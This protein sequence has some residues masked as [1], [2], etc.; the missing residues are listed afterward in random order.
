[1][2]LSRWSLLLVGLLA[3]V[4]GDAG[5]RTAAAPA[6]EEAPIVVRHLKFTP[7]GPDATGGRLLG[8]GAEAK[9]LAGVEELAKLVGK[10]SADELTKQADLTKEVIVFVSWSSSGPP[11]GTLQQD[12]KGKDKERRVE[13]YVKEPAAKVR[14]QALKLGADFYAVPRGVPVK[15]AGTRQ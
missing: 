4:L 7:P 15:F 14:G 1:M 9:V 6:P 3:L 11:F 2:Y 12:V 13:F 8:G 10:K 5:T